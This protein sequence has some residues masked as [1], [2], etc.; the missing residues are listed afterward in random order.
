[1]VGQ[2]LCTICNRHVYTHSYKLRCSI[3]TRFT[4]LNCLP[5]V[6]RDDR[7]YIDRESNGWYCSSCMKIALPFNHFDDDVDFINALIEP[8]NG[9]E[10]LFSLIE[11]QLLNVN[12]NANYMPENPLSSTDPDMNFFNDQNSHRKAINITQKKVLLI[13]VP[14]IMIS[15]NVCP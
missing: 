9:K 7:L 12:D 5:N 10:K 14:T 15:Q 4:H 1:M 2:C 3:C 6:N 8:V 13:C 11:K